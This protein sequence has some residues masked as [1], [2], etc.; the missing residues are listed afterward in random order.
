MASLHSRQPMPP[1]SNYP[2]LLGLDLVAAEHNVRISP[3]GLI[4]SAIAL[5]AA[6]LSV[7]G[8]Q[9]LRVLKKGNDHDS[10][11]TESGGT[12]LRNQSASGVRNPR[13]NNFIARYWRG[14]FSLPISYWVFGFLANLFVGLVAVLIS[15]AL[16]DSEG[17]EPRALFA[18]LLL[19]WLCVLAVGVWQLVG[20]WRSAKRYKLDR[21]R[22]G[23]QAFW[24]GAAQLAVILGFLQ[25]SIAFSNTGLPQF[26]E[27]YRVAFL[28]DPDM[29]PYSIRIMR[30]GTETE[31]TGGFKYGLTDDFVRILRAS[32]QIRVVHLNSVGG[33]LGEAEKLYKLIRD[34]G[35]ITYV[36]KEC[37]SAC[38]IAF[39]AGRERWLRDGAVLGF[40]SPAF[41]GMSKDDLAESVRNQTEL[42]R[43]AGFESAFISRA[44]AT[45]NDDMWM[46]SSSELLRANVVTAV[47]DGSD[48]AASGY[49]AEVTRESMAEKLTAA[50]PVLSAMK[51]RLPDE[52]AKFLNEFYDGYLNGE[53]EAKIFADARDKLL[54]LIASYRPLADDAVLVDLA[55][56]TAEQY[57]ALGNKDPKLCYLFASGK[58]ATRN[59]SSD[60]PPPLLKREAELTSRVILTAAKRPKVT[61]KMT[62]PIWTNVLARLAKRFEPEQL[63]LIGVESPAPRQY[64]DYCTVMIGLFEEISTLRKNEA[65]LLM[66]EIWTEK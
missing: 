33:R 41:P 65:G 46:P 11:G 37:H 27:L 45:P 29:P 48:F 38:T 66:R 9:K 64:R 3:A 60:I 23:K 56:L 59:F 12:G 49:G 24:A 15:G 14:E 2:A 43:A 18:S 17:Y 4:V 5:S 47:S 10:I 52:Y 35:L 36:S 21:I 55:K 7:R 57:A 34:R 54:P 51:E 26:T 13:Y 30:N 58:G 39:A 61:E 28:D 19:I 6:I 53:T 40:H 62:A 44:L 25:L 32:P 50:L 63:D 31:I 22:A 20:V 8:A 16:T 1:T 42:F